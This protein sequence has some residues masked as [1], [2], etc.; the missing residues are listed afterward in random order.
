ARSG[1]TRL[2]TQRISQASMIQRA[3]RAGR[4]M[5]GLCLH[6]V[7][8]EQASRAAAQSEPE[9]V[10]SDL[11]SLW[12]DLL[13]WGCTQPQQLQWL[14]QPPARNLDAAQQQLT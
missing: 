5:P 2:Q 6:L 12:L 8:Q 14:D 10:N 1:V 4:L 11:S 7:P 9:I 13:Q 3:G